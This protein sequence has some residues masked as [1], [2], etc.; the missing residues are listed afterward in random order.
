MLCRLCCLSPKFTHQICCLQ[1]WNYSLFPLLPLPRPCQIFGTF[2]LFLTLS[3]SLVHFRHCHVSCPCQISATIPLFP[4]LFMSFVLVKPLL[5]FHCFPLCPCLWFLSF[6]VNYVPQRRR[7]PV[8]HRGNL[9]V[10]PYVHPSPPLPHPQGFVSFGAQIQ[11]VWPKSKQNGLNPA[12]MGQI[13][14]KWAKSRQNGPNPDK[15]AKIWFKF[16]HFGL[17]DLD[18]GF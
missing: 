6:L 16:Y 12:K 8:E 10:R 4:T 3:L 14:A 7:S 5:L 13:Q 18:S 2:S 15:M 11:A 1:D 17:L 9:S